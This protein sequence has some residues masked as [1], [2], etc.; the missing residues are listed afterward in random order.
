MKQN[1]ELAPSFWQMVG[2]TMLSFLGVSKESRRKR[3]FQ[4]GNPKVFIMT[5]FILALLFIF[6]VMGVVKMVLPS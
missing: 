4:H 2:S 6:L 3:D 5:G 1:D